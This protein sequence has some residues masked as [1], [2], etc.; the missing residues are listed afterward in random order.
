[1]PPF[2][3][4]KVAYYNAKG[5]QLRDERSPFGLCLLFR[6]CVTI[7]FTVKA[8]S[9]SLLRTAHFIFLPYAFTSFCFHFQHNHVSRSGTLFPTDD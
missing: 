5:Y 9:S 2:T 1:M 7:C 4:Q 3:L 8:L 6:Y